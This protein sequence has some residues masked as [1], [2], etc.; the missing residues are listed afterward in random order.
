LLQ[1]IK[2]TGISTD[3]YK[4]AAFRLSK[5]PPKLSTGNHRRSIICFG[6]Y[7]GIKRLYPTKE[8]I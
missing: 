6:L 1:T 5:S 8:G 7:Y 3:K 4:K 2:R